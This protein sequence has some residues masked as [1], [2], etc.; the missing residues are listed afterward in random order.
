MRQ[1]L[2]ALPHDTTASVYDAHVKQL[3][4]DDAVR[5]KSVG[6]LTDSLESDGENERALSV[7]HMIKAT[8]YG[9]CKNKYRKLRSNLKQKENIKLRCDVLS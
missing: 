3:I 8:M 1:D 2:E 5:D 4:K 9:L 7:A 6:F